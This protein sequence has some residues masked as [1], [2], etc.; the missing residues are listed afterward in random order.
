MDIIEEYFQLFISMKPVNLIVIY[1]IIRFAGEVF[2]KLPSP[3]K[4]KFSNVF[5]NMLDKK[6]GINR[7]EIAINDKALEALD[8]KLE[9]SDDYITYLKQ[10]A[11]KIE[12]M[13]KEIDELLILKTAQNELLKTLGEQEKRI[14]AQ[15][16]RIEAQDIT[17]KDVISQR[18]KALTRVK[19]NE[20]KHAK[21]I[22]CYTKRVEVLE[23]ELKQIKSKWDIVHKGILKLTRMDDADVGQI[24]STINKISNELGMNNE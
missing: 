14:E 20:K 18:D 4:D 1:L 19:E 3:I 23:N 12:K 2:T 24:M 5:Y 15:D 9:L 11:A 21:E 6:F 22:Q 13:Q 8:S 10:Q 7:K 16:K 17:I